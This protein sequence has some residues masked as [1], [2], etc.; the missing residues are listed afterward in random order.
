M[1]W[2]GGMVA[3]LHEGKQTLVFGTFRTGQFFFLPLRTV[4][5]PT[6][7]LHG[8]VPTGQKAILGN[9]SVYFGLGVGGDHVSLCLLGSLWVMLSA[10]VLLSVTKR[11]LG[12]L[13]VVLGG[14]W[15]VV[16]SLRP[17]SGNFCHFLAMQTPVL[18]DP[19]PS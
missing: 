12:S 9:V 11:G 3:Y 2:H 18:P 16:L 8:P 6:M 5:T 19:H 13:F 1:A 4:L 10:Q 15:A 7:Q 14:V 17:L